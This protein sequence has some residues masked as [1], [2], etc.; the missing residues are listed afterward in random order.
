MVWCYVV[1]VVAVLVVCNSWISLVLS[2]VVGKMKS[3]C[4]F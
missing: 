1:V 2:S 4:S 3:A